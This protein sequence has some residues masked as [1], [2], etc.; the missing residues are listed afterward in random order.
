MLGRVA[1]VTLMIGALR[2]SETSELT[3]ATLRNIPE[4]GI[5]HYAFC[6]SPVS[7]VYHITN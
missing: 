7:K 4:D 5:F 3:G 1:L 2:S 6:F